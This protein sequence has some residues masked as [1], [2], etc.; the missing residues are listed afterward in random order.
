MLNSRFELHCGIPTLSPGI[1]IEWN[2]NGR[3]FLPFALSSRIY[4][5]ENNS[6]VVFRSIL[7]EDKGVYTCVA[8]DLNESSHTTRLEVQGEMQ[9]EKGRGSFN[10]ADRFIFYGL[11]EKKMCINYAL[12]GISG[13][14][15]LIDR[16]GTFLLPS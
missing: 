3:P 2:K 15:T 6:L 7:P 11:Q 13:F 10:Y 9:A 16:D 14:V 12:F 4:F 5:L 8:D 1:N